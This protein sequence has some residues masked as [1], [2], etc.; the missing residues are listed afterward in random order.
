MLGPAQAEDWRPPGA[1]PQWRSI[2]A[3]P[4]A[5]A[6]HQPDRGPARRVI[7]ACT[8]DLAGD[9]STASAA[10]AAGSRSLRRDSVAF[11]GTAGSAVGIQAPSAG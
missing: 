4:A 3:A 2:A 10:P 1:W 7:A 11:L 6:C 8:P 9:A 5:N